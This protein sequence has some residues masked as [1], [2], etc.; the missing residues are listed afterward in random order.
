MFLEKNYKT[1]LK[2]Y[3]FFV[4][5][6]SLY[7]LAGVNIVST[8]NAM[9]EW[10]INYQGGFVRRGLIG[11]FIFQISN[12]FELNLRFSFLILQCFLYLFF[13]YLIYDLLKNIKPNYF[14]ILALFSPIFIFFPIAELEA[15]GRKEVLIFI[16][17]LL[18]INL[19]FK[20][21]NNN[22]V[23]LFLSISFPILILTHEASI[24]YSFFFISLILITKNKINFY[25]FVKLG[26]F[27]LPS[28]A[29][30]Y[31]IYFYPHTSS[32]TAN[33]CAELKKVGEE[34]GLAAAFISKRI[35]THIAE[36]NWETIHVLRYIFI[37]TLGFFALI[38]LSINSKF[39]VEKI[40]HF[41][42]TKP[43][44]LHL[45]ILILPSLAMFLIAVD[46]GRWTHMS[47]T[48]SFIYYFGLLKN[49]AIILNYKPINFNFINTK[50]KNFIYTFLFILLC[51][52]WNPKA[53]HHE[54]LGSLPYYRA[55]EKIP[56]YY[57]NISKIKIFR[58][59]F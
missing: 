1:I 12:Y 38:Y 39:N 51:F 8:Y 18:S 19:Y 34:C 48:C 50:I 9:S 25:Y 28:L 10:V 43:F 56:N 24:F 46:T 37:F 58:K 3:I 33:M 26:I 35:D 5:F 57:N 53:V 47:Y 55:L 45:I 40:N 22:F 31:A 13:Y 59:N 29:C 2:L 54:D 15:I 14:V 41:F 17:L 7:Y 42:S 52:S 30:I 32:E 23:I 27:S 4:S 21:Y 44:Y 49:K 20:Y 11:E 6:L 36:V 16:I